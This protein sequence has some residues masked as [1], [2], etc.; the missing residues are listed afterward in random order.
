MRFVS[1]TIFAILLLAQPVAAQSVT[2]GNLTPRPQTATQS[3]SSTN[4][5]TVSIGG[6]L[7]MDIYRPVA[8]QKKGL[9]AQAFASARRAPVILFVH[10]GGWVKG[11]REKVYNLPK[12]A[13]QRGYLL[14]STDYRP[15]P[16]TS[17]DGQVRDI[18]RAI[19]WIRAN[20]LRFGGD[21]TKIVIMGH[22]AGSHLVSMVAA[23]KLGGRLRGVVANDV[24][25]YDLLAYYTLRDNSMAPIYQKVFGSDPKNW[26]R[27]SPIT[28]VRKGRGYPPFLILYSRSDYE[29]RKKLAVSFAS[30]LRRRGTRVSL[31]DGQAYTHGTIASKIGPSKSVTG[32]VDRLLQ[33]AFTI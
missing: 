32:A 24:Q 13:A 14:A 12:Y 33:A 23:K 27:Y 10:G 29:R 26:V 21:P 19:R 7:K 16:A 11:S 1:C 4:R 25:A 18:V 2:S 8:E 3:E 28:Y 30:E 17:I 20:I 15:Y 5:E 22:S 9:F 31:F 6:G